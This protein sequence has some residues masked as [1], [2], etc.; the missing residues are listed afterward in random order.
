[1]PRILP[2]FATIR[3]SLNIGQT[4]LADLP[5]APKATTVASEP[6]RRSRRMCVPAHQPMNPETSMPK[7][8]PLSHPIGPRQES[9]PQSLAHHSALP[10]TSCLRREP[11]HLPEPGPRKAVESPAC[12]LSSSSV[13]KSSDLR[14]PT[15]VFRRDPPTRRARKPQIHRDPP[16]VVLTFSSATSTS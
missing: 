12:W 11:C 14:P 13:F 9:P 10:A 1:M 4:V 15:S 6:G 7:A 3:H 2:S 16:G 5:N 8:D